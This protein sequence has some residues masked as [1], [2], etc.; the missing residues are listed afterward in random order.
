MKGVRLLCVVVRCAGV[1]CAVLALHS[2]LES[3][4]VLYIAATAG[5]KPQGMPPSLWPHVMLLAA[6]LL[7][8]ELSGLLGKQ[9]RS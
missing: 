1:V 5:L 3:Y 4:R 6:G 8:G 2:M 9:L 7:V